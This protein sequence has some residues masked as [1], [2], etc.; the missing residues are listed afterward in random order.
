MQG[1]SKGERVG[2]RKVVA[3]HREVRLSGSTGG[4]L[5]SGFGPSLLIR[6]RKHD[7]ASTATGARA[8]GEAS[9]QQISSADCLV[10]KENNAA[11]RD[12]DDDAG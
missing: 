5:A 9:I 10:S 11:A 1:P 12:T 8:A 3:H 4:S 6:S 7:F 2:A